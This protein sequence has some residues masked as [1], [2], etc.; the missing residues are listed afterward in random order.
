MLW[1]KFVSNLTKNL[2]YLFKIEI[3]LFFLVN[4]YGGQGRIIVFSSTKADANACL[5]SDKIT[6]DVEVMLE[7]LNEFIRL[8]LDPKRISTRQIRTLWDSLEKQDKGILLSQ[9]V[10]DSLQKKGAIY[11]RL[12]VSYGVELKL[13]RTRGRVEKSVKERGLVKLESISW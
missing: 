2:K 3:N 4:F 13:T 5:L 12:K 9:E 11:E 8:S 7:N 10:F 1:Q 6:H